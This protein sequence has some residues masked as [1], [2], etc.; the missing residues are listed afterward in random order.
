MHARIIAVANQ[1]GGVGKTTTTV[2][3]AHAFVSQG[4]HVLAID[5]DPQASLSI[6]LGLDPKRIGELEAQNQ[7]IYFALV[8]GHDL[9]GMVVR[10]GEGRPD[11]V[12]A[13]ISLSAAENEMMNPL[14]AAH[15]LRDLLADLSDPYDVIVID[16]PPTLGLLTV[17]GLS[18]ASE[19]L[20][21]TKTDYLSIMGF[22][23]LLTTIDNI[24]RK[25]NPGLQILGVLPTLFHPRNI[26]DREVLAELTAMLAPRAI[27]VFEP[28]HHAT[29]FDKAAAEG[30]SALELWPETPG[31]QNYQRIVDH[32]PSHD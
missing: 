26:H 32:K 1:K 7:T 2:N 11:L 6:S 21:P 12:P 27:H 31:V 9:N 29:A 19:V 3:L 30:R 4:S 23:L 8:K 22:A 25:A 28:I 15:V 24:R 17:N 20:I 10:L 13:S 18:A 16:C 5:L 14:G